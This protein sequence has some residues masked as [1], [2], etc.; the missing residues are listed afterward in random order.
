MKAYT[1]FLPLQYR[2][3]LMRLN[4]LFTLNSNVVSPANTIFKL[5]GVEDQSLLCK[6]YGIHVN[7]SLPNRS[8]AVWQHF[9]AYID[10]LNAS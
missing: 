8:R 5:L 7:L 6:K 2:Y 9:S 1:G 3:D 10:N 4:F